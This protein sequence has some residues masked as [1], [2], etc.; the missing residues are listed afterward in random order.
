MNKKEIINILSK[1]KFD[2]NKFC[3]IS[4][5]SLILLGIIEN[6]KDIDIAVTEEYYKELIIDYNCIFER[7]NEF[8]K[9]C[10]IIFENVQNQFFFMRR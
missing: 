1:Y 9:D 2:K 4:G 7:T 3:I 8:N 6:T 10:Y 5:A